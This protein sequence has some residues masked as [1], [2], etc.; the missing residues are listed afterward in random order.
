MYKAKGNF[1]VLID[2]QYKRFNKGDE[3]KGISQKEIQ[4]CLDKGLVENVPSLGTMN[5][6]NERSDVIFVENK[7]QDLNTENECDKHSEVVF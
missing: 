5:E 4:E 2:G 7:N 3:V 1:T 6:C